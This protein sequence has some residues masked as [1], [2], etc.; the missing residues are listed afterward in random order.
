MK[1]AGLPYSGEYKWVRTNMYWGIKHEV[2]PKDM[3]LSC[4]QCH[5]SLKGEKTCD[6]CHQ[7]RCDMD[8]KKLTRAGTDFPKMLAQGRDVAELVN[9]TDYIDFKALGYEG[10]PILKGGR[11]KKLPLGRVEP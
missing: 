11:F 3:A 1:A 4:V 7:D 2:M 9:A 6:R 8:F 10:D 5:E